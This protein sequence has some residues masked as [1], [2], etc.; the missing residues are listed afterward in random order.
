VQAF[1][2]GK[3]GPQLGW[4]FFVCVAG[5]NLEMG[6]LPS[7]DEQSFS[8]SIQDALYL[9]STYAECLSLFQQG[10]LFLSPRGIAIF[11]EGEQRQLQT[12]DLLVLND[13]LLVFV[14]DLAEVQQLQSLLH[15]LNAYPLLRVVRQ[16]T[17]NQSSSVAVRQFL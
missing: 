10:G 16:H 14:V 12:D 17:S 9:V 8:R 15:F 6:Y 2:A 5:L 13:F 11:S 1:Y 7:N 3:T 4:Q